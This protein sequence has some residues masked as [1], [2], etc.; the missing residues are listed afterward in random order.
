V[1]QQQE[2]LLRR[3]ARP[4]PDHEL[5]SAMRG[6]DVPTLVLFGM[7]DAMIPYTMGR[8]YRELLPKCQLTL[9]Y[10]AGHAIGFD[11]PEAFSD[12]VSDFLAHHEAFV[13]NQESALLNP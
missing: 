6:L 12:V 11:R 13:V 1:I 4:N 10:D 7:S 2:D 8:R 9:V 3:L 5:E